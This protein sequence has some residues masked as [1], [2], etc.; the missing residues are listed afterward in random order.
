MSY[1]P[2]SSG[3][4]R[5]WVYR[6]WAWAG[7]AA[8]SLHGMALGGL[9]WALTY[10]PAPAPDTPE[11]AFTIS[12]QRLDTDTLAG[13][14][15]SNGIA[16]GNAGAGT[17]LPDPEKGAMPEVA[18]MPATD[19][20]AVSPPLSETALTA[21]PEPPEDTPSPEAG[22]ENVPDTGS[23]IGPDTG[24]ETGSDAVK[25][26]PETQ[27]PPEDPPVALAEPASRTS[28]LLPAEGEAVGAGG[29]AVAP[30]AP[31]PE[32]ALPVPQDG[33]ADP[34]L[35][36]AK[37]PEPSSDPDVAQE[38]SGAG[39][40]AE[41]V[42]PDG[43]GAVAARAID[44][45]AG[46]LI[47]KI[48]ETPQPDCVVAL[49]RRTLQGGLGLEMLGASETLME[50]YGAALSKGFGTGDAP[51]VQTR[52]L[53][54]PRQCAALD[55]VAHSP[56]YPATRL[57]VSLEASTTASG[58]W[59]RGGVRGTSG[60][61]VVLMLVDTNGVVQD[62]QRFSLF[63]E[64]RADFAVPVTRVGPARD[65]SYLVLALASDEPLAALRGKLGHLAKDV[66]P[67]AEAAMTPGTALAITSFDL[68]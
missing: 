68:R 9:W 13:M 14:S 12:L 65:T 47:R 37:D 62:L 55:F 34:A 41:T 58:G 44:L 23:D 36:R 61:Y 60:R 3:G 63:G 53:V 4:N 49:P 45:A 67:L 40:A 38:P 25:V 35:S 16:N 33:A 24:P 32:V 56:N 6:D 20:A 1:L 54:D 59:L 17:R 11:P 22:P 7:V 43:T 50:Q 51:L 48:R 42:G 66:M 21:M 8:L 64:N 57:G 46:D 29:A 39:N 52:R 10:A 27:Q 30:A 18:P 19:P 26:P 28:P 2:Y 5:R 15:L 31:E